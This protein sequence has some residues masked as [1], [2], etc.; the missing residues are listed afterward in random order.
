MRVL[1]FVI[2]LTGCS[3]KNAL[4]QDPLYTKTIKYTKRCQIIS[5]LETKALIDVVYLNPLYQDKFK[6]Q[7]FLIGVYNDFNNTLNNIEFNITIGNNS[8]TI[9]THIPNFVLYKHFPF[10]NNWM[11]Y[12]LIETNE[13]NL[14]INYSSKD[15]GSCKITF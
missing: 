12:Y 15:W 1:I 6:N 8:P 3:L 10:Y 2:L 9:K 5:S 4:K 13:T 14:T 11:K 7:A